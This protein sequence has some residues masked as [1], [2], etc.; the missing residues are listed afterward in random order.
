MY[1]ISSRCEIDWYKKTYLTI[2]ENNYQEKRKQ[3]GVEAFFFSST[4]TLGI[5]S[6]KDPYTYKYLTYDTCDI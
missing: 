4:Q 1:V 5:N 6:K 2:L 3:T